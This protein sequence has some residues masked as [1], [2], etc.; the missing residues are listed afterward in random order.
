LNKFFSSNFFSFVCICV[1]IS[2]TSLFSFDFADSS[3]IQMKKQDEP[4]IEKTTVLKDAIINKEKPTNKESSIDPNRY[5]IGGGDEFF[6]SVIGLPAISY[7]G[8]INQQCDMYI[9]ELGLISLGKIT[10]AESQKKISEYVHH[11]LKKQNDI[12]VQLTKVKTVSITVNGAVENPGTY[13]LS[14]GDR[15][16][17][18]IRIANKQ[19]MPSI[20]DCDF[21]AVICQ[22]R[23][24]LTQID[25][26]NYL[27]KN[28]ISGN[29]YLYPGDNI[30]IVYATKK[31]FLNC[32][33]KTGVSGWIPI[34]KQETLAEFL[35]FHRFD[36][37]VDTSVI[38]Y[39][40]AGENGR[41]TIQTVTFNNAAYIILHDKDVITIPEKQNYAPSFTVS[42]GGE[43]ARPGFFSILRDSTTLEQLLVL[44]GGATSHANINRA[45]IVRTWKV[46]QGRKSG[47]TGKS[48][49]IKYLRPEM[50]SGLEKMA[51]T[52]DFSVM[53]FKRVGTKIKLQEEDRIYIPPKENYV[54][55]SGCVKRP[56][57][58][59]YVAGE[60]KKHYLNLA[61]GYTNK[62]SKSNVYGI[63][64]YEKVS[65][66]TDLSD[67]HEGDIIIVP[68][69]QQAKTLTTI[70]LPV[71]SIVYT[72]GTIVA[73]IFR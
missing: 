25:M 62:A 7:Y 40:S 14:G 71:V 59:D 61:G 51:S 73:L 16:L 2:R 35:A 58:Y 33:V 32:A 72:I 70:I 34:K 53:E 39:Q 13:V 41:Q 68:E 48:L 23:D 6:I 50:M 17:D 38:Y 12:Y 1:I 9:P 37:S 54:Y 4:T 24:S 65:Q 18:A 56:G 11:K 21:R 52:F 55:I 27:L 66:Q 30:S 43:V 46:D 28:D 20:N 5:Y 47:S 49:D 42:I 57:A 19:E 22:N 45:V 64:Y 31:V 36:N 3:Y 15:L 10:L 60:N 63:R 69:S 44:A 29:P 67:V 26:F 8:T